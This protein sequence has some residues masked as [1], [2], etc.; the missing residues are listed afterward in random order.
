MNKKKILAFIV[1]CMCWCFGA[2]ASGDQLADGFRNPPNSAKPWTYW[3]WINGNITREGIKAD[4]EAMARVGIHGVLIMEVAKPN[5]PNQMAPAGP[6]AFGSLAWRELFGYA[7]TE[8]GRLGMEISMNNDAGW[9][10]SGG[11]WNTPEFSMQKL[12][13]T[14]LAVLGSRHC[15]E[16]LLKPTAAKGYYRDIKVLAYPALIPSVN[17]IPMDLIIDL[18]SRVDS[19]GKLVWDVP[20]GNW[21]VLRI[22]HTTNE[23]MNHPAPEAGLG[24]ECDKFNAEAMQHHFAAFIDK[25]ADDVGPAA[26]KI[27][28]MT[29]I[30]SWEVG[31]QNWTPL[32]MME[33]SRRRGYDLTPWLVSLA[34]GPPLGSEELTLRFH[35]DFK[36]TQSEL[37]SENYSAVLRDLSNRRGLKLSIEAY[38][39]NCEFVN[40]LNYGAEADLPMAE[41]WVTRWGAWHL[42]SSRLM[43]SVAHTTGKPIVGAESFTA[44][45]DNGSW[46]EHPYSIKAGGDWA[47]SEGVNHFVFHR[48]VLQPWAGYEPGMTFGPFG[49]HFDRNQTWWEPGA[50]FMKYLARCQYLLQQGLFVADLCRLVPDGE[51]HGSKPGIAALPGC[52]DALPDG[53]NYDYLSDKVFMEK[54]TVR[55]GRITLPGGMSYRILQL[56]ESTTMMPDLLSKIRYL[57]RAGAIVVGPRP[58]SS[59]S[60]QNYPRCDADVK[61]LAAELWGDCNGQTVT[62][63]KLGSG[64]VFWGKPMNEVLRTMAIRTDTRFTVDPPVT[65]ISIQSVTL[66]YG[67]IMG[68]E[69]PRLMPTKGLNWIHRRAGKTDIY[70]LANPQHRPVDARCS[71]RVSGKQ[72]ELW[73][74]ETGEVTKPSAF[75]TRGDSTN[76]IIRFS[77]AGSVFVVFRD[78]ANPFVQVVRLKRDGKVL[79]GDSTVTVAAMPEFWRSGIGVQMQTTIPGRY[80]VVFAKGKPK[81]LDVHAL[82]PM[83]NITGPWQVRFQSGRGAPDAVEFQ[84]LTDWSKNEEEGIRYFSG[85]AHYSIPFEW[86]PEAGTPDSKKVSWNRYVLDLGKVEV[87]AELWLNGVNLGVLWKPPFKVDVTSTLKSGNN[88]LEVKVTNLWPNRLIGD[89]HYPDD[90]TADGTWKTGPIPNWP[91]WFLRSQPRPEPRRLTF[92]TW[93]YYTAET[94]LLASGLL[95]P[96][97]IQMARRFDIK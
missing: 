36:R 7:V 82:Q 18:T 67:K 91:E 74:P 37:V 59:P 94:P 40:S 23:R 55:N 41:F 96:V 14:S 54:A 77:P 56:P 88:R 42:L 63:H 45:V 32:M 31:V 2:A 93:K 86:Q 53:V 24:L 30:D 76:L 5:Q 8:A 90:C 9:A 29:H 6:V 89:E 26:G 75:T 39:P 68:D 70:F 81:T 10:G 69:P 28:T 34:G 85:T 4:L 1:G 95:G 65:D 13:W 57:V 83:V 17:P 72:P 80:E 73:D 66:G 97:V 61:G 19:T 27:F 21:V 44:T 22:G 51:N 11:P 47:F 60:L 84:M 3:F 48:S 15:E 71:F 78:P 62:E 92:T 38:A 64:R 49:T 87:L 46:T 50:A 58:V 79:L 20:D 33:F 25:L 12:V 43:A 52:Y 16:V 35:R